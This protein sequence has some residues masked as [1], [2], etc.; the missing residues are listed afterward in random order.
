MSDDGLISVTEH[1]GVLALEAIDR[2]HPT[3]RGHAMHI[4]AADEEEEEEEDE[5]A[6]SDCPMLSHFLTPSHHQVPVFQDVQQAVRSRSSP[7]PCCCVPFPLSRTHTHT[8]TRTSLCPFSADSL[9]VPAR[10][11][12][13]LPCR[14]AASGPQS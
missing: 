11:P 10:P 1:K 4:E 6:E 12:L 14:W 8:H 2:A 5:D 7:S 13:G 3:Y 9:R